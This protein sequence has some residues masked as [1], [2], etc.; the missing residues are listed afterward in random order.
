MTFRNGP[1]PTLADPTQLGAECRGRATDAAGF[2]S[3]DEG[4]ID[5]FALVA[6]AFCCIQATMSDDMLA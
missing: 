5:R 3:V 2:A 4:L 6:L 1:G